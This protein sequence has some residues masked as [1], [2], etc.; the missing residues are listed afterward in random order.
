MAQKKLIIF[1]PSIEGG[2]VEK[3]LFKISNFLSKKLKNVSIITASI[4]YKRKF[5]KKIELLH[6]VSHFWD[7]LG[8]KYKYFICLIILFKKII[9]EK[10][11]SSF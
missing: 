3:N 9:E 11:I 8:R 6:P 10:K 2:G 7:T 5:S 4:K 1:M